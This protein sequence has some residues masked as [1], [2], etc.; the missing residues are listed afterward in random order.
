MINYNFEVIKTF[1]IKDLHKKI[2]QLL[3]AEPTD[4]DIQEGQSKTQIYFVPIEE[5]T[6]IFYLL[7]EI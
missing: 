6:P 4:S 1:D 7:A 3:I 2:G 5:K